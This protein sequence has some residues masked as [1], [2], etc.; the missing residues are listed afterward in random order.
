MELRKAWVKQ[1]LLA[2]HAQLNK[3]EQSYMTEAMYEEDQSVMAHPT[4][5]LASR[6][7]AVRE[8]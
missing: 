7:V 8:R 4:Q 5:I 1:R 6:V 2:G 3:G